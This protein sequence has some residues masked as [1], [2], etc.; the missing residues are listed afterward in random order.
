MA[1]SDLFVVIENAED[2][3]AEVTTGRKYPIPE[4]HGPLRRHDNTL[5]CASRGCSSPTTFSVMMVPRCYI[6][7]LLEMNEMLYGFGVERPK[8]GP[9][10][11]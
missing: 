3:E 1:S 6:H 2:F 5:R 4:Q 7:A 11:K 9:A 8:S 10:L